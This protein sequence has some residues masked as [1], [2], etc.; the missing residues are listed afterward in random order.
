M[1]QKK[2]LLIIEDERSAAKALEM[3]M[4]SRG[5]TATQASNGQEGVD[6]LRNE[7]FDLIFCDLMMPFKDGFEVLRFMQRHGITTPVI[8]TSNLG[9]TEDREKAIHLG[10]ADYFV[11]SDMSLDEI[12]DRTI[13]RLR[14]LTNEKK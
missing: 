7:K 1:E 9:Q 12:A 13:E 4:R 2:K 3:K 5:Y 11:K 6:I 10:A 8:I 14:I